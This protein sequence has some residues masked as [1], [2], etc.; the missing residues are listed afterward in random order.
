M[1]I[2]D[3]VE[4][5]KEL[6]DKSLFLARKDY[7]LATILAKVSENVR[8]EKARV[9]LYWFIVVAFC[10]ISVV[11]A[12]LAIRLIC[13]KVSN[14]FEDN[15]V[16]YGLIT[17]TMINMATMIYLGEF[18]KTK[19][20]VNLVMIFVIV[21]FVIEGVRNYVKGCREARGTY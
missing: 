16:S 5:I 7:E 11:V 4:F 14:Y 2:A 12:V 19:T 13:K 8:D 1:F 3:G 10:L 17:G 21:E 15:P 20:S 9:I 18:I 6:V